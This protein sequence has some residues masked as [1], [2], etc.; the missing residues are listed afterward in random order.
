VKERASVL[1]EL[2]ANL[3]I[4]FDNFCG[5]FDFESKKIITEKKLLISDLKKVFANL[6]DWNHDG[7]KNSLNEFATQ[8]NLKIKDFGPLL[9][10]ILTFSQ[11]SAGGIFDVIEILGKSEV[12]RRVDYVISK[13]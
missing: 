6:N 7:I 8:K 5:E 4:Y 3:E 9:R 2:A 10:I 11:A 1:N 13:N 12:E